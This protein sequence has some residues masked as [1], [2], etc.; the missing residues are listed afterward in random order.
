MKV[1]KGKSLHGGLDDA[2]EMQ[3]DIVDEFSEARSCL[4]YVLG[5]YFTSFHCWL[6]SQSS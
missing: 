6:D 4:S 1:K 2:R 5:T 3:L